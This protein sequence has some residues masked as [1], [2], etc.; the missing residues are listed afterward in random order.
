M[1]CRGKLRLL[2][3][4]VHTKTVVTVFEVTSNLGKSRTAN[5]LYT[6][7]IIDY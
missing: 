4:H 1:D 2:Q 7:V 6:F 5:V 3:H